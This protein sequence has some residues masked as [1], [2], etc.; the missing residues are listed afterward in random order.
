[1]IENAVALTA[2]EAMQVIQSTL[3]DPRVQMLRLQP[4]NITFSGLSIKF[5]FI[6]LICLLTGISPSVSIFGDVHD[7]VLL[8]DMVM[9]TCVATGNPIPSIA[10]LKDGSPLSGNALDRNGILYIKEFTMGNSGNY[11]CV[12]T[13]TL[14]SAE[15]NLPLTGR[16]VQ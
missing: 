4:H 14:G 3:Q 6:C 1:M 13:S 15:T 5:C 10:W 7:K 2:P 12:A 16:A 9:L 8:G 11:T